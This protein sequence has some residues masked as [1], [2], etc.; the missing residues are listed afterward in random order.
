M[1]ASESHLSDIV[2]V[3]KL[4]LLVKHAN[5]SSAKI[6]KNGNLMMSCN[7]TLFDVFVFLILMLTLYLF[8]SFANTIIVRLLYLSTTVKFK[9]HCQRRW[10]R[11]VESLVVYIILTIYPQYFI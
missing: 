4:N 9:I 2:D 7:L 3:S 10:W 5:S 6:N 8:I 1:I 11:V